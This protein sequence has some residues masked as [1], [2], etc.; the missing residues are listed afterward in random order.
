[1][2]QDDSKAP[3]RLLPS[4]E[5]IEKEAGAPGEPSAAL[6][7][8][9]CAEESQSA[10]VGA[11]GARRIVARGERM[12]SRLPPWS[13]ST[14]ASSPCRRLMACLPRLNPARARGVVLD[15]TMPHQLF[16]IVLLEHIP[17]VYDQLRPHLSQ[18]ASLQFNSII[19]FFD[20][21]VSIL[22]HSHYLCRF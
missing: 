15:L 6:V 17:G 21:S 16:R 20:K 13:G 8:K 3:V 1:M 10:A 9:A 18:I 19:A 11:R 14:K 5:I 12:T 2:A 7:E 4:L 22:S